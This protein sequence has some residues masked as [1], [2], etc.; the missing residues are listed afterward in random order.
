MYLK[1][2]STLLNCFVVIF[3]IHFFL[4]LYELI[5]T[6]ALKLVHGN[7]KIKFCSMPKQVLNLETPDERLRLCQGGW[8]SPCYYFM[9]L[10]FP[11]YYFSF[12]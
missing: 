11:Y 7:T 6:E 3:L 8:Q 4:F 9:C 10:L 12:L 1:T 2:S 5:S